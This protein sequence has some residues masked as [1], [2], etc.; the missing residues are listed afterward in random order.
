MA[1]NKSEN[2]YGYQYIWPD[3]LGCKNELKPV[4]LRKGEWVDRFGSEQGNFFGDVLDTYAER[5]LPYMNI[6]SE[7]GISLDYEA[8]NDE[9]CSNPINDK[10]RKNYHDTYDAEGK[11]E[12]HIYEVD[13]KDGL[14]LEKCEIA[15][16]FGYLGKGHQYMSKDNVK[17][18]VADGKIKEVE[19]TFIPFFDKCDN[20]LS[21]DYPQY[22]CEK[23]PKA[24][25][26]EIYAQAKDCT[27]N[28]EAKGC[29]Q[30]TEAKGG[31]KK[32]KTHKKTRSNT[33]RKKS[34]RK[35]TRRIRKSK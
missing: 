4:T 19:H 11:S 13:A 35:K 3:N 33:K 8:K 18:L 6:T 21:S 7:S 29:K 26:C 15:P 17:K 23:Y 32:Y 28:P 34:K 9:N 1:G 10:M 12:Y 31:E 14:E 5:S 24:K 16:A 22:F 25:N 27:R 20:K 2:K 30:Y